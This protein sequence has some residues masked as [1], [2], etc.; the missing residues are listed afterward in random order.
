[1]CRMSLPLQNK[2][3]RD[4]RRLAGPNLQKQNHPSTDLRHSL[5]DRWACRRGTNLKEEDD[6]GKQH[7][8]S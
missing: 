1:M 4:K 2:I 3:A 8:A 6:E 5:T 7:L